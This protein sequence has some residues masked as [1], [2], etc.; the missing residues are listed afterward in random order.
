MRNKLVNAGLALATAKEL[1]L[2]TPEM[3]QQHPSKLVIAS[4]ESRLAMHGVAQAAQ[5]EGK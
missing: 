2:N 4:R 3:A 1:V 5:Q